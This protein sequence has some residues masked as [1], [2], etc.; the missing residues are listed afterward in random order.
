MPLDPILIM[1]DE[2]LKLYDKL[3]DYYGDKLA[4][5]ETHPQ[6]FAYQVKMYKYY[7]EPKKVEE[8]EQ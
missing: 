5:F 8:N 3:K 7:T 4:D 6:T 1:T 2:V